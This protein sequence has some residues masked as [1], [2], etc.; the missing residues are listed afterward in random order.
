[1]PMIDVIIACWNR[2]ETIERA[3][4]S[5][6]SQEHLG[7]VI[8]V[9]D[10][11]SDDS[12][13]RVNRLA[14]QDSRVVLIRKSEN[15]GPSSARNAALAA[16]TAPWFTILDGD[17][18]FLPGRLE[19]LL[20]FAEGYDFVADNLLQ[21]AEHDGGDHP[22]SLMIPEAEFPVQ[23]LD[24]QTFVLGNVT[25]PGVH[26]KE[27]GF[28]K[29]LIRRDFMEKNRL[30]YDRQM[31]LGEDFYLYAAALLKG[32]RFRLVPSQG[33]VSVIRAGSLSGS[34]S[35]RDL[36]RLRDCGFALRSLATRH[37]DYLAL[38]DHYRSVDC[39]VQWLAVIQAVKDRKGLALAKAFFRSWQVSAFLVARLAEQ[40]R[41]RLLSRGRA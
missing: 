22:P 28:F 36:E 39:R 19:G 8:V 37:E 5:A 10:G 9:D 7:R 41:L 33:Y 30:E 20:A 31:R 1:M 12:P 4:S 25:R 23:T 17:D 29:P 14:A 16:S 27:L 11:S 18:Y 32:A 15:E 35:Q 26:R 40:V 2:A 6:L 34:H 13:E 38:R 24:F 21:I 3:I